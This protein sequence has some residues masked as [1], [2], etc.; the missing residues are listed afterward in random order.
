[1]EKFDVHVC[2]VSAQ[3]MP[4]FLPV[5]DR[6]FRPEEV[7][8]LVSDKMQDKAGH[9]AEVMNRTCGIKKISRLPV[10]NEYEMEGLKEQLLDLLANYDNTQIAVN[11]T[12]GTK[13]MAIAAYDLCKEL[14]YSTFYFTP[15]Q[16]QIRILDKKVF[17]NLKPEN[18]KNKLKIEDFLKLHGYTAQG[19]VQRQSKRQ[20]SELTQELVR[21]KNRYADTLSHFYA[22]LSRVGENVLK[23]SLDEKADY[24]GMADLLGMF[25]QNHLLRLEAGKMVFPDLEAKKYCHG[26][27]FE[28]H[29]FEQ[30]KSIPDVQDC[31]LGV[32]VQNT[33]TKG[34]K[35]QNE[36]DVVALYNNA[37]YVIE[38][39]TRKL[40]GKKEY[41]NRTDDDLYK[42]NTHKD[43]GGLFTKV[44][45]V[46]Y[47]ELS[48]PS[49]ARATD[50]G[51][52]VVEKSNLEGMRTE[53][54]KWMKA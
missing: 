9:L 10:Q 20:L 14:N 45:F 49:R 31:A 53:L 6:D 5:L 19:E 8:L 35:S 21:G 27:W 47:L 50:N 41:E 18:I 11:I 44:A 25:E 39:K 40:A 37:M 30:V 36:L 13:L 26:G 24:K 34:A 38:C 7:V 29:V 1:M 46:S 12:G 3:P 42:L 52:K 2:L 16:N 33:Q 54:E 15:N 28:E 43:L 51:I 4:N 48:P 23:I 22:I 17:V 32:K